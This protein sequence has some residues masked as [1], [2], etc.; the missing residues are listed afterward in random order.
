MVG[1]QSFTTRFLCLYFL[2]DSL[3]AL[4]RVDKAEHNLIFY[5]MGKEFKE[6]IHCPQY[7]GETKHQRGEQFLLEVTFWAEDA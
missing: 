1:F 7:F 2:F 3:N 5:E 6:F 4:G